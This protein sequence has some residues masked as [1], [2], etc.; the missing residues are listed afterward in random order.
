MGVNS[1]EMKANGT[2]A[3]CKC[4]NSSCAHHPPEKPCPHA[5]TSHTPTSQ[6]EDPRR[7]VLCELCWLSIARYAD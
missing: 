2:Q 6:N 7:P 1:P 4:T 3:M 5:A